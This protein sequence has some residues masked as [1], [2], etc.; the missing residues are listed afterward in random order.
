[1]TLSSA[2]TLA[3]VQAAY[4]DNASYEEAGSVAMAREF[5]TACRIL[6]RRTPQMTMHNGLNQMQIN[7][8]VIRDEMQRAQRWIDSQPASGGGVS[9]NRAIQH[10]LQNF[11]E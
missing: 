9:G 7:V 5:V 6:L 1:M 8:T 4:D 2:S 3:Q 11:R 10:T